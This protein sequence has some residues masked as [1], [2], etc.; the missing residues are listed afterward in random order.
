MANKENNTKNVPN[1]VQIEVTEPASFND[2]ISTATVTSSNLEKKIA[3]LFGSVFQDFE[4][5]KITPVGVQGGEV[6]KCKL[7]FKPCF[8]KT[9]DG[10]YAV[11]V[12]GENINAPRKKSNLFDLVET[13]NALAISKQFDLEDIAKDMLASFINIAPNQA[14]VEDRYNED[15]GKVVKISLPK[16]WNNFT[17][18]ITDTVNGTRFQNPYLVVD[19]DLIPI[20]AT[21]YGKKDP[22]EV[23]KLAPTGR[24]PKNR[25]QY[26]VNIVKVLNPTMKQYILEIRRMDV[27][28]LEALSQNIGYGM[29]TGS[30]VMTRR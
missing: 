1:L 17:T 27:K 20:I 19:L 4:G 21:L 11:K 28:E 15:Y 23:E 30:I 2:V 5:C 22:E 13:V 6:L 26:S 10:L 9:D 3:E 18:E 14:K 8:S 7:Y 29:V 24:L 12:K 25:Y 16:N